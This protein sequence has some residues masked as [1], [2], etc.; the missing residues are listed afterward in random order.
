MYKDLQKCSF[1]GVCHKESSPQDE[2]ERRILSSKGRCSRTMALITQGAVS[3]VIFFSFCNIPY[4]TGWVLQV[5][6]K[7]KLIKI[8][9]KKVG[10]Y[11]QGNYIEVRK[12]T[13]QAENAQSKK[14]SRKNVSKKIIACFSYLFWSFSIWLYKNNCS[15]KAVLNLTDLKCKES[16]NLAVKRLNK[17][18]NRLILKWYRITTVFFS[19]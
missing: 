2:L 11:L 19:L 16:C 18:L 6:N 10:R 3:E 5:E 13:K 9:K 4:L 14:S 8:K 1:S 15:N 7:K 12:R 17:V